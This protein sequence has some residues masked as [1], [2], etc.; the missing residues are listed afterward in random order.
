M[1]NK[2]IAL[3]FLISPVLL[4]QFWLLNNIKIIGKAGNNIGAHDSVRGFASCRLVRRGLCAFWEVCA[5]QW[6]GKQLRLYFVTVKCD[7]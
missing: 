3:F 7:L 1:A 5:V 4:V 6:L 2:G